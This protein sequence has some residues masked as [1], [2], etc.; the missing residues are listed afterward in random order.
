MNELTPKQRLTNA[1]FMKEVDRIPVVSFTQTGTLDLMSATGAYWPKAHQDSNIMAKLGIA[2]HTLAGFEGVRIPFGLTGEAATMG[3]EVDYHEDRNDFTPNIKKG[4]D[5]IDDLNV[6]EPTE[7]I[8]GQILEASKIVKEKVGNDIPII[9]GVTGPFTIA[10]HIRGVERMMKELISNPQ[11]I[12]TIEDITSQAVVTFSNALHKNGA[13]II[14]LIEPNASI[15]GPVFFKKFISPYVKKAVA[16][17][18]TP[19]VLHICGNS[20]PLMGLMVETGVNA[21]SIDQ[22]ISISKAIEA[23]QGRAAIVGNVDPV[24][25]LLLKKPDYIINDCQRIIHEGVTVL[26]PGCG[27]SPYTPLDN[28]KAMVNAGK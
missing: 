17:I 22:T 20:L 6:P 12:H 27:L 21:I 5:R 13:D 15:I 19:T 4:L 16:T 2:G 11:A 28:I 18:K 14:A 7:G 25:T 26:A 3:C 1:L 23:V 9:V 10:G 24:D 8:M